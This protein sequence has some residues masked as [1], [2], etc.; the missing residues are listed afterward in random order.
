MLHLRG[1]LSQRH[2]STIIER[3]RRKPD[4]WCDSNPRPLGFKECY[5]LLCNNYIHQRKFCI[6]SIF[7]VSAFD[8]L[9]KLIRV[10]WSLPTSSMSSTSS[11]SPSTSFRI[12]RLFG[13]ITFE[14]DSFRPLAPV[15][16]VH[17]TIKPIKCHFFAMNFVKDT[18]PEDRGRH[19]VEQHRTTKVL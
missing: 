10:L 12:I 7:S 17:V 1:E 14:A 6:I 5:V 4:T 19:Q 3:D 2:T 13:G 16:R 15:G 8:F 9:I 11:T 18:K